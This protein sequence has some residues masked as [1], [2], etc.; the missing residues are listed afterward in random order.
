MT[1]DEREHRGCQSHQRPIQL[2]APVTPS[3]MLLNE[4]RITNPDW[5][6]ETVDFTRPYPDDDARIRVAIA[7][8]RENVMR[9]SGGPFGAAVFDVNTGKLV[10]VGT[11]GVMRLNNSSAHAEMVALALAQAR[12]GSFTL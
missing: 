2:S 8:A 5:V 6:H 12:V 1:P 9:G 10:G 3:A 4:I 7:L 11:N